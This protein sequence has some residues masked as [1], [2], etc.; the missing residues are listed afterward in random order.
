[1]Q[2]NEYVHDREPSEARSRKRTKF[3]WNTPF[4]YVMNFDLIFE[5]GR[6]KNRREKVQ[7]VK[8]GAGEA[9]LRVDCWQTAPYV[10]ELSHR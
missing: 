9:K 2:V 7:V 1:M 6:C 10:E 8:Q 4:S 5:A 3:S